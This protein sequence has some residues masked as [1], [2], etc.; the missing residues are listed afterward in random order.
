MEEGRCPEAE[1]TSLLPAP[2][3]QPQSAVI[4]PYCYQKT[5]LRTA[6]TQMFAFPWFLTWE[7]KLYS[8]DSM[9]SRWDII[10]APALTISESMLTCCFK[11]AL[12]ST[13]LKDYLFC[14]A[15]L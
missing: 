5:C 11:A 10:P 7:L 2:D 9:S 6:T 12:S 15:V 1:C 14:F 4:P 8:H 13:H 3:T